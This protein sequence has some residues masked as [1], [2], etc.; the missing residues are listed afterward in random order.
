MTSNSKPWRREPLSFEPQEPLSFSE[1]CYETDIEAKYEAFHDE[2]GD[3]AA[4]LPEYKECHYQEYIEG[5]KQH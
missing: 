5:F 1:W 4:S 3:L 2:Y